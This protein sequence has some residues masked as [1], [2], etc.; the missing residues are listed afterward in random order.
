MPRVSR[1]K[2]PWLKRK[3]KQCRQQRLQCCG[4]PV[5]LIVAACMGLGCIA[6]LGIFVALPLYLYLDRFPDMQC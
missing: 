5:H 6:V 2:R 1:L 3:S 4:V